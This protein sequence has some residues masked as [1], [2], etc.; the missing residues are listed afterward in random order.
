MSAVGGGGNVDVFAAG[1]ADVGVVGVVDDDVV[2]LAEAVSTAEATEVGDGGEEEE[3]KVEEEVE[4][5]E[6]DNS[7]LPGDDVSTTETSSSDDMGEKEIDDS[8]T[9]KPKENIGSA[10]SRGWNNLAKLVGICSGQRPTMPTYHS[11]YTEKKLEGCTFLCNTAIL[12]LKTQIRGNA[13]PCK[14]GTCMEGRL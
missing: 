14:S 1:A 3:A 2:E 5:E 12:P 11:S 13:P 10:L 7:A 9:I 8:S 4:E 6:V